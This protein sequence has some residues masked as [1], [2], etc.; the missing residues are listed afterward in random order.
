MLD[1]RSASFV[2]GS[3]GQPRNLIANEVEATAD[4]P[5][6]GQA[7]YLRWE[8][9]GRGTAGASANGG[10]GMGSSSA[11]TGVQPIGSLLATSRPLFLLVVEGASVDS[12][13]AFLVA[14]VLGVVSLACVAPT[15]TSLLLGVACGIALAGGSTSV[16]PRF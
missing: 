6:V 12:G 9:C 3:D 2:K 13:V 4:R 10:P 15:L 16:P 1:T 5:I 14:P 8:G 11:T 7:R